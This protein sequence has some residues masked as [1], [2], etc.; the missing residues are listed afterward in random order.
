MGQACQIKEEEELA[1]KVGGAE[2]KC[3][4]SQQSEMF[5]KKSKL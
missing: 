3:V 2:T 5:T 4:S 1:V